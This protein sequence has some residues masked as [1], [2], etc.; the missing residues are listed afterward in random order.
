MPTEAV[1]D[2]AKRAPKGLEVKLGQWSKDNMR[3]AARQTVMGKCQSELWKGRNT[4]PK[5]RKAQGAT[6]SNPA[7]LVQHQ[8]GE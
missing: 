7:Q 2:G 5:F 4:R 1:R 6:T 3:K 8:R